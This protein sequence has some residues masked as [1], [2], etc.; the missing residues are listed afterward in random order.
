M[1]KLHV[2]LGDGFK[3]D[4]VRARIDGREVFAKD[5]VTTALAV[6]I[7]DAFEVELPRGQVIIE[8]VVDT[9]HL[10]RSFPVDIE[11]DLEAALY[12][13]EGELQLASGPNVGFA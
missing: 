11:K 10:R 8:V 3:S 2:T 4:R 13:D 1:P 12:I 9:R 7:A 5:R 6:G